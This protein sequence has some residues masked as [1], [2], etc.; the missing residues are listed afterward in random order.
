MVTKCETAVKRSDQRSGGRGGLAR[1]APPAGDLLDTVSV[2]SRFSR[3]RSAGSFALR[4]ADRLSQH[5]G[6]AMQ[7][8]R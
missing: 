4:Q 5:T 2:G 3:I 7:R 1:P 8:S 6:S